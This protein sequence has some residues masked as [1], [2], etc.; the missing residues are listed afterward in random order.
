MMGQRFRDSEDRQLLSRLVTADESQVKR[1][2]TPQS[3]E[4]FKRLGSNFTGLEL[5]PLCTQH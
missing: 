4:S 2:A 3:E 5:Q 1:F